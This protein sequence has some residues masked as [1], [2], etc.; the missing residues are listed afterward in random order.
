[1]RRAF[2]LVFLL[3]LPSAWADFGESWH[4]EV[5]DI[6]GNQITDCEISIS[7]P[8]TG[9]TLSEPSGAMYQ[10]FATC[11]GYVVMWHKPIP[12]SQTLVILT[13]YPIIEDLFSVS[14]AHSIKALDSTWSISVENGS[15]DAPH[16]P[17]IVIGDGGSEVRISQSEITIPDIVTTYNLSG[18]YSDLIDVKA[19]H[20]GSGDIVEWEDNNLT[21]GEYGGGWGARVYVD[22]I[23]IG[24]STW[25]PSTEW[26][27]NQLNTTS[28]EGSAT[29]TFLD[30]LLK[31]QQFNATWSAEHKFSTGL[32]LP[33]IP[34][35]ESGIESQINRF[36][37]GDVNKLEALLETMVFINGIQSLCCE[38]DYS[39]VLF[40]NVSIT[41]EINLSS[42][43]WGWSES[44][45]LTGQR[46]HIEII[47]I[48][49]PFQNDLRQITPLTIKTDGSWQ[50][51]SSPLN[52]WING[53]PSDF[54]IQRDKTSIIGMHTISLGKNQVPIVNLT[55]KTALPWENTSYEFIPIISDAAMSIHNC[56]WDIGGISDNSSV[57]LSQFDR[58]YNLSVSVQCTD[59]GGKHG[60]W[61]DSFIL[62]DENPWINASDEVQE[63]NPGL[64]VWDLMVGDDN[65]NNLRVF[66]TSNKTLD[67]WYTGDILETSFH[68]DSGVNTLNDN[69]S[70]RHKARNPVEY[71]LS[72]EITDDAGHSTIGNWTIR[73]L[74]N[75]GPVILHNL[76][77]F[78]GEEWVPL[79]NSRVG[80]KIR[81]DI[82]ES[83]DDYSAVENLTFNITVQ[84]EV[85]AEGISWQ[86]AQYFELPEIE[87][88][89]QLI[90]VLGTDD[91]GNQGGA[92]FGVSMN[93]SESRDIEIIKIEYSGEELSPGKNQF[94]VVVQNNGATS[95]PFTICSNNEC[96]DSEVPGSTFVSTGTISVPLNVE[97]G[98]FDTF[99]VN[100]AYPDD[101]NNTIV[102]VYPSEYETGA[103]ISTLELFMIV[104][105]LVIG[106]MWLRMRNKSRF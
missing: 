18:N 79:T 20:T 80:D 68:V 83:F 46:S 33:F 26:I 57:N 29:L 25:P 67:W 5:Q 104:T 91:N 23:P 45:T 3:L 47:R 34:G 94:W 32:G 13:A 55:E 96:V 101:D 16:L 9:A 22:E 48:D 66:W 75:S 81:I 106:I 95:T 31:N 53:T 62:D 52:D 74:D 76:Q 92:Y 6:L 38:V 44:A 82:T 56:I 11:D 27:D 98:W 1:M 40:S 60:W 49:V 87:I 4:I 42:N 39:E 64:F 71:W 99:T 65:D 69:I 51:L 102:E 17:L 10:P 58:D 37:S 103:G 86:E 41:S 7:D 100:L 54:T 105:A 63:I 30:S 89:Y 50:F 77:E 43:S 21:V 36:L 2:L 12:T 97:L 15:V 14:G 70:E 19:I 35:A 73:L 28:L 72:A 78:D 8:W 24:N 88:G 85:I 59:E 90:Q 84:G 61:N 93:P